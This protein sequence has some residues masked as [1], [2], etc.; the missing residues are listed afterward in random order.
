MAQYDVVSVTSHRRPNYGA[1]V[2]GDINRFRLSTC[3]WSVCLLFR[4]FLVD[5]CFALYLSHNLSEI[6]S[7][8]QLDL[9][10][11]RRR[12]VRISD[13][14]CAKHVSG[15]QVQRSTLALKKINPVI[16]RADDAMPAYDKEPTNSCNNS[17]NF[18]HVTSF[19]LL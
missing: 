13:T 5:A 9:S 17:L 7:D 16:P 6:H 10:D 1:Y 8:S 11:A 3:S 12:I 4:Y 15:V 14:G 18:D 19:P 2:P